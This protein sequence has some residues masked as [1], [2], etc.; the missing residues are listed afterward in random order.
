[1]EPFRRLEAVAVPLPEPNIDTDRIIPARFLGR[2][3]GVDHAPFLFHDA[4][5]LPGSDAEE[6]PAFPLNR[7]EWRGAGIVVAGRNFACGSS[8]EAAVWALRDAGVRCAI[9]PSFGDIF[10]NNG[11]KNGFLPVVLP[12]EAVADLLAQLE[13]RPGATVAVDLP[14]QTVVFP[15][16]AAHGFEMDPFDKRC[17]L[18]GLDELAYTLSL[19]EEI[20]AFER[21]MGRENAPP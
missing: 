13:A 7:A 6:D 1:M 11:V 20:A 4:R 3:R 5:R 14:G 12:A 2:L 10:R 8:R 18:E 17:L 9:A 16:G 19:S 21:R 15:D